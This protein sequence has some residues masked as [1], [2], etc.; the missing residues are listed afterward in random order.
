MRLMSQKTSAGP[1]R[2]RTMKN[3]ST[4]RINPDV[5]EEKTK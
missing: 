2:M 3:Y 1:M 5:K 4:D